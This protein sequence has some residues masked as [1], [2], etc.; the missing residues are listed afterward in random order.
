MNV[1]VHATASEM[2]AKRNVF[3]AFLAVCA[4][5]TGCACMCVNVCVC[6]CVGGGGGGVRTRACV[7]VC[8]GVCM[9]ARVCCVA[10][11]RKHA[12]VHP[13]AFSNMTKGGRQCFSI[14]VESFVPHSVIKSPHPP[15]HLSMELPPRRH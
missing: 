5:P 8:V 15:S 7:Y 3:S 9:C 6:V 14:L 4:I 11:A 2:M 13:Y 12:I 10:H 1:V